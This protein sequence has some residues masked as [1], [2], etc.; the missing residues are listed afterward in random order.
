MMKG[1]ISSCHLD[2][3]NR[4]F[5]DYRNQLLG[6]LYIKKFNYYLR[7]YYYS[8]SHSSAITIAITVLIINIIIVKTELLPQQ[9]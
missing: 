7:Y 4:T 3:K 5:Y 8:H 6:R 1:M 2:H 9:Q